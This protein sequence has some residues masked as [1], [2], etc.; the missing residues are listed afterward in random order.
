MP[1]LYNKLVFGAIF[2]VHDFQKGTL[3]STFSH[4][5]STFAMTVSGFGRP[6]RDPAF[7]ETI[8]IIV[9]FGPCVFT[10]PF[11]SMKIGG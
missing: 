6:C 8:V 5:V 2:D 11:F 9:P 3:W 10:E 7:H 4:K 1:S